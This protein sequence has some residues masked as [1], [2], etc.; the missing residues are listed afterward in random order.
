M[1]TKGIKPTIASVASV[2]DESCLNI[3]NTNQSAEVYLADVQT[4]QIETAEFR[5]H[6]TLNPKRA[7]FSNNLVSV[8]KK[9]Y[10]GLRVL[11][12][13]AAVDHLRCM[14]VLIHTYSP[15]HHMS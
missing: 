8:H 15:A 6:G 1:K 12:N 5:Q 9:K 7:G 2:F 11:A 4:L 14:K 3:N 13:T 10:D